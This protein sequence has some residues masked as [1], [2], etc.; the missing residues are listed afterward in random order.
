MIEKVRLSTLQKKK[1]SVRKYFEGPHTVQRNTI[2]IRFSVPSPPHPLH[3]PVSMDTPL[4]TAAKP[5]ALK[6]PEHFAVELQEPPDLVALV[7][8]FPRRRRFS[9]PAPLSIDRVRVLRYRF[10]GADHLALSGQE[11]SGVRVAA[12]QP[13]HD[14]VKREVAAHVEVGPVPIAAFA[15]R[16]RYRA[17]SQQTPLR[18]ARVLRARKDDIVNVE[19]TGGRDS[20]FRRCRGRSN[21]TAVDGPNPRTLERPRG[22]QRLI[23]RVVL[24]DLST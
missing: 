6:S 23:G 20:V 3:P 16:V 21:K 12:A 4:K 15:A 18:V 7:G 9:Q 19:R 1:N 5:A 24:E 17:A 11:P 2:E 8:V 22:R 13:V 14:A 10:V